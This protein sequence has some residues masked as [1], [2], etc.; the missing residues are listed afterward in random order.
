MAETIRIAGISGSLRKNSYNTATLHAARELAP[1]GMEID[2]I[3]LHDFPLFNEDVE[4]QG[5]P[6]PVQA[7][8]DRVENVDGVIFAVAEYNYG[9]SGVLKNG[10]DWLSRP[11]GKGPIV[12]KPVGIVGASLS[13]VGTARAQEQVRQAAFYNK[14]PLLSSAEVLIAS[15]SNRFDDSGK[16]T[17]ED[18]RK[19]LKQMLQAM[20]DWI[21]RL[22]E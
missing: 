3:T 11:T 14:M 20:R 6:A 2:I 13:M 5:W 17:D 16:L 22:R 1:E 12:G 8:R 21:L 19:F 10:I 9:M 18:T 7:V 15:A 4:A